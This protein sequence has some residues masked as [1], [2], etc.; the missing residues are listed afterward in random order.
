YFAA[1][2]RIRAFDTRF[3]RLGLLVCEDFWHLSCATIL[4]A[5]EVDYVVCISNSP[6]R[7][8]AG[9]EFESAAAWRT[10]ARCYALSLTAVV[11]FANRVGYEDGVCFWGGSE[12]VGPEGVSAG[13]AKLFEPDLLIVEIEPAELRR[14]RIY[15]PLARDEKLLLTIAELERIKAAKYLQ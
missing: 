3:G 5:D 2:D 14:A 10:L 8:V 6:V 13:R 11:V 4:G 12:V 15:N 7:G 9:R 1:G